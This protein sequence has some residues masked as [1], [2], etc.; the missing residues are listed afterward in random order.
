MSSRKRLVLVVVLRSLVVNSCLGSSFVSKST[1]NN[2]ALCYEI[3]HF[4]FRLV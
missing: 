2:F 1:V 4:D 3:I